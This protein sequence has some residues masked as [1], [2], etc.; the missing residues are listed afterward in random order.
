MRNGW[1][2]HHANNRVAIDKQCDK[3]GPHR[4]TANVVFGAIDGVDDP[5]P[6]GELGGATKF[7][8]ENGVLGEALR[9]EISKLTLRGNIGIADRR[10]IWFRRNLQVRGCKS[11]Q[12]DGV[13]DICN[14]ESKLKIVVVTHGLYMLL[15]IAGKLERC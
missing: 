8:T 3:C 1:R 14:L 5:L 12:G 15:K 11:C 9:D 6:A 13:C 4:D 2:R 7:L 10:H